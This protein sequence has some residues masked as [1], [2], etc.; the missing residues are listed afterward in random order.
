MILS[1]EQYHALSN[2]SGRSVGHPPNKPYGGKLSNLWDG[3]VKGAEHRWGRCGG[4]NK[5]VGVPYKFTYMT[6]NWKAKQ[7]QRVILAMDEIELNTCIR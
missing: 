4:A 7:Q 1:L 5:C 2:A 6:Y 3:H